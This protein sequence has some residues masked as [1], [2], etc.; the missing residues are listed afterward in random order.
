AR[1][2]IRVCRRYWLRISRRTPKRGS[3]RGLG[4]RA[5]AVLP[6]ALRPDGVPHPLPA[7]AV[8]V[9]VAVLEL[10]AGPLRR[11]R[12]EAELDLARPRRVLLRLPVGVDVPAEDDSRR[13]VE[14]EDSRPAGDAPV[15]GTLV[16]E[17]A[18]A[19]LED[20][21]R[22]LGREEVAVVRPPVAD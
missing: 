13:A 14:N 8:S 5:Q 18:D 22:D 17:A 16:D 21:R 15:D 7:L 12:D 2:W 19:Q 1:L 20:H 10:D 9:E 4:E 3:D 11:L 6:A